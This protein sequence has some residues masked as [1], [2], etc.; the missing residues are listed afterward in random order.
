LQGLTLRQ[1][2]PAWEAALVIRGLTQGQALRCVT[3]VIK[4]NILTMRASVPASNSKAPSK[5]DGT[6][7]PAMQGRLILKGNWNLPFSIFI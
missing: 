6:I 5:K 1:A 7:M 3:S 4:K 2:A